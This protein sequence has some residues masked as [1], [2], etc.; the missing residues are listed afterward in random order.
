MTA[1]IAVHIPSSTK[2]AR[3]STATELSQTGHAPATPVSAQMNQ[4]GRSHRVRPLWEESA[5][6][7]CIVLAG[8]GKRS[9]EPGF[10]PF[11]PDP[12]EE[13]VSRIVDEIAFRA[14]DNH[15]GFGK[16]SGRPFHH[17]VPL[18]CFDHGR[19]QACPVLLAHP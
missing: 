13:I 12:D 15:F 7:L 11:L 8:I 16:H 5:D 19:F 14:K 6:D 10:E 2:P 3:T 18:E 1:P 4:T 9:A 17:L